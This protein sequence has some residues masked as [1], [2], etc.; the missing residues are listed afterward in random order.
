MQSE[1]GR[2][3]THAYDFHRIDPETEFNGLSFEETRF[4]EGT[5]VNENLDN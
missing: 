4:Q 1:T 3:S 2:S 5:F